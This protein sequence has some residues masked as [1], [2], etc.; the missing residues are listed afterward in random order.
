MRIFVAV[1][2]MVVSA[3]SASADEG[4]DTVS[5][6]DRLYDELREADPEDWQEIEARIHQAESRTGSAAMD[7]L[8]ARGRKALEAGEYVTAVEHLT[9]LTELA[10]EFA[11]GWNARAT[12]FFLMDEYGLAVADIERVLALNPRHFGALAGLG[13]ILEE[14]GN[15]QGALRAYRAA[16]AIHPYLEQVNEAVNRLRKTVEGTDL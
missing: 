9:A 15:P 6:L 14:T 12:A 1:L 13:T 5:R 11:E 4:A 16:L 2:I 7:L 8:F 10:P 3:W